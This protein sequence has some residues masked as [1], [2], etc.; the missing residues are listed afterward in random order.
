MK[1][2]VT[3]RPNCYL[4]RSKTGGTSELSQIFAKVSSYID[5]C[6]RDKVLANYLR[7]YREE[8]R[9]VSYPRSWPGI[10]RKK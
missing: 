2:R 6:I 10:Y 1:L 9:H 4:L 8:V 5:E 3:V 7:M